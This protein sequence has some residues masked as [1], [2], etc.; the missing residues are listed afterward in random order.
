MNHYL[1][2]CVN[3]FPAGNASGK[4]GASRSGGEKDIR[5]C[6]TALPKTARLDASDRRTKA[7]IDMRVREAKSGGTQE[8]NRGLTG[9]APQTAARI[10][11]VGHSP[12]TFSY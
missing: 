11:Y 4:H 1:P 10:R 3:Y 6:D 12:S 2:L 7:E 5:P 9:K 8:E